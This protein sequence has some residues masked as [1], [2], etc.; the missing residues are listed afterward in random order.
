MSKKEA[1]APLTLHR[2]VLVPLMIESKL[3][4]MDKEIPEMGIIYSRLAPSIGDHAIK[5]VSDNLEALIRLLI[6]PHLKLKYKT[7][8]TII[9]P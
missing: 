5:E 3:R 8:A 2:I 7:E 1:I 4:K 9:Q 6:M